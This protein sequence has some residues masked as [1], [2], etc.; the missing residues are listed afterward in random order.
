MEGVRVDIALIEAGDKCS[1]A[2]LQLDGLFAGCRSLDSEGDDGSA[3]LRGHLQVAC[4]NEGQ[5]A[6]DRIIGLHFSLICSA[7]VEGICNIGQTVEVE[8]E[9]HS[10]GNGVVLNGEVDLNIG[11]CLNFCDVDAVLQGVGLACCDEIKDDAVALRNRGRRG[12]SGGSG[13]DIGLSGGLFGCTAFADN[14]GQRLG[15]KRL[16]TCGICDIGLSGRQRAVSLEVLKEVCVDKFALI[17]VNDISTVRQSAR[18]VESTLDQCILVCPCL[19]RGPCGNGGVLGVIEDRIACILVSIAVETGELSSRVGVNVHLS[20][21]CTV[22]G[23]HDIPCLCIENCV[24]ERGGLTSLPVIVRLIVLTVDRQR[25]AELFVRNG[26]TVVTENFRMRNGLTLAA[27]RGVLCQGVFCCTA[28]KSRI[29]TLGLVAVDSE[30]QRNLVKAVRLRNVKLERNL[31]ASLG[32]FDFIGA[33]GLNVNDGLT[34]IPVGGSC[35][36][37]RKRTAQRCRR[38]YKRR[39]SRDEFLHDN[40]ILSGLIPETAAFPR[41]NTFVYL[42]LLDWGSACLRRHAPGRSLRLYADRNEMC[43]RYALYPLEKSRI[44]RMSELQSCP[45]AFAF[46]VG[47]NQRAPSAV[48]SRS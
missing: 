13:L 21:E 37:H 5:L 26:D 31:I 33:V 23:Y 45:C 10:G 24:T 22:G 4:H 3:V 34:H 46:P 38:N 9:L 35:R 25:I 20:R 16:G 47:E 36:A 19:I 39:K 30:F 7:C 41:S 32:I 15:R 44:S 29:L 1:C 11:T 2:I 8:G 27:E 48:A 43:S 42:V 28:A 18:K 17:D 40:L 14:D 6:C 12:R